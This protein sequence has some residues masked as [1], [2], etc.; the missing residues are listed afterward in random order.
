MT[1]TGYLIGKTGMAL[2][3]SAAT[4]LFLN[5]H[6]DAGQNKPAG[7]SYKV[8]TPT[9]QDNLEIFPIVTESTPDTHSFLTLDEGLR[10]GQVVVTEEGGST[11]LVRPRSPRT[12]T[13]GPWRERLEGRASRGAEV[14][15]LVLVNN[16]DRPLI[17][18]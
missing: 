5:P 9:T 17:L 11:G 3:F 4:I 6:I 10:S 7:T 12:P 1:N 15:R 8:L 2:A 16:S 14:N 18:L 13:Q